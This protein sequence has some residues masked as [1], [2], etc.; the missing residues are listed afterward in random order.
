[1][2]FKEKDMA[3]LMLLLALAVLVSACT[4]VERGDGAARL[5]PEQIEMKK[6]EADYLEGQLATKQMKV[7]AKEED[8]QELQKGLDKAKEE[9]ENLSKAIEDSDKKVGELLKKIM[10]LKEEMKKLGK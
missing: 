4:A 5:T 8:M 9:R 2:V 7:M 6:K 1:M 3:K 10:K